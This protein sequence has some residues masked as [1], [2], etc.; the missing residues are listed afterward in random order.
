MTEQVLEVPEVTCNHCVAAIEGAVG[1]LQGVESVKVNLDRKDV[2]INFDESA[3]EVDA[4]V[5]AITGE[6]YAVG[7]E[8]AADQVIQIGEKPQG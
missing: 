1:A 5:A 6:G 8:A 7:P 3:L 4:I 2:T